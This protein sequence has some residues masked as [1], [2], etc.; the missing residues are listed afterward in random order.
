MTTVRNGRWDWVGH[1]RVEEYVT[2]LPLPSLS[3]E[4]EEEE[5]EEEDD[6][7]FMI[8]LVLFEWG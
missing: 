5:E 7:T 6:W 2:D 3:A 1:P 8:W 4:E